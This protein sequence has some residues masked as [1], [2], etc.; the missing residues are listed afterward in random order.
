MEE[1]AIPCDASP[2]GPVSLFFVAP[3]LCEHH[4]AHL[5]NVLVPVPGSPIWAAA[6]QYV[7]TFQVFCTTE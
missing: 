5:I 1:E 7:N 3:P 4:L 2:F 6:G